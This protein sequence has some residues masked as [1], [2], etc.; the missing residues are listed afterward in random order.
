MRNSISIDCT[1]TVGDR[2]GLVGGCFGATLLLHGAACGQPVSPAPS[3]KI[4]TVIVTAQKRS[5]SIQKVPM[6]ITALDRRKLR[7][8][9]ITSSDQL[10]NYVSNVQISLPS[11]TGNQPDIAIRGVGLNDYN[12]NNAGPNGVYNDDVYLS[13]PASQTFQ[14]FDLD[15]IEVLKG[16]QGTLY[17]RN[18]T[19]GAI[20]YVSARPTDQFF[21]SEDLTYGSY[22]TLSSE[23]VINGPLAGNVDGRLAF[24]HNYSDGYFHD[25]ASGKTT[26]GANDFAW[27]AQLAIRLTDDLTVDLNFHG[28]V[29]DRRPD[30][31]HQLGT[32]QAGFGPPCATGA[33]LAGQCVDLYGYKS[34]ANLY[35][36][37][38]NRDQKLKVHGTG[39]YARINYDL[40]GVAITSI[41]AV[42]AS[43][44]FQ[45]EDTD[46]EP[47]RLLEL[48][49]AAQSQEI[50]QE[51]RATFGR[52]GWTWLTGLSYLHESL[53]DAQTGNVLLGLDDF[54]GPG[55]GD[56]TAEIVAESDTQSTNS[57]A[58]YVQTDMTLLDGLQLTL[59]GR[60]TYETK[61][62]DAA[63][64]QSVEGVGAPSGSF[65]PLQPTYHFLQHLRNSATSGRA[66]LDYTV[67]P[68]M[69]VYASIT[70][71][72][73]S[74]GFN[75]GLL[76]NTPA[77]ALQQLQPIQP[78]TIT[79]YEVGVKSDLLD[80]RL[81]LN[82]AGFY[83]QYHDLQIFNLVPAAAN[84]GLPVN[85]LTNAPRATIKGIDA[86]A[87]V[88][89]LPNLTL[90]TTLG[91]L[92]TALGTFVNGAGTA[93]P[94]TYTGK[95]FPLA[96]RF[97]LTGSAA[98][99]IPLGG[100]AGVELS[101][102][103]SYRT[104]QFFDSSND[105]LTTQPAYWLVDLRAEYRTGD[106]KWRA[107]VFAKNVTGT[108]YLNYAL[109]LGNPFGLI[110]QVVGPPRMVGGEISFRFK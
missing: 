67:R 91:Y 39:G 54:F 106:G 20:N 82:A 107:A 103:A 93:A 28:G 68:G 26:N 79:A 80:N 110:Q 8:L 52:P 62:F 63:G 57:E 35:A 46:A 42:E 36:G 86:E 41:T 43:N 58:A 31:Y 83:Y 30:E 61:D 38:Y 5:Q 71:G 94:I 4:D 13:A 59:G 109:D 18:A 87:A 19:G 101:G 85:V 96:P 69:L 78:E 90:G 88:K 55:S 56:G 66:A 84:G 76:D 40:A 53:L 9:G 3:Q 24:V 98:Y 1:A 21:A 60:Y 44:R 72:F 77:I 65:A 15:R 47:Y 92:D 73:K 32:L 51:L 48:N 14:T 105:P 74:G 2:I 97:S 25:N 64:F 81:R 29:V 34:P 17:G 37:N 49:Y 89:P 6:T 99:D 12:S 33:V 95:R 102:Q 104:Q 22:N 10:G 11:G 7:Q 50:S 100:G 16:P 45:P 108:R 70:T 75:G 27:R 23:T